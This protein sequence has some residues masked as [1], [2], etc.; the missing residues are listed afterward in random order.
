MKFHIFELEGKDHR[1]HVRSLE[2][3][4]T[5][6]EVEYI[7]TMVD[8]LVLN[9]LMYY[10][11]RFQFRI[12]FD[13]IQ[14]FISQSHLHLPLKT[15]FTNFLLLWVSFCFLTSSFIKIDIAYQLT[16]SFYTLVNCT[17]LI[18]KSEFN[19]GLKFT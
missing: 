8:L 5:D 3:V 2:Q 7:T 16:N 13:K 10:M 18:K 19:Y 1:S 15:H 11:R 4:L 17:N 12:V 6:T 14:L 9:L